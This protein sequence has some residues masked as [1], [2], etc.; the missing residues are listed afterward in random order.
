MAPGATSDRA[1]SEAD[2]MV[3]VSNIGL[4]SQAVVGNLSHRTTLEGS[5]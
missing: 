2:G 3:L 5:W 4:F 1:P